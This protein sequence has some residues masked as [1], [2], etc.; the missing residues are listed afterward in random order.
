MPTNNA[1]N[2][3]TAAA[4]KVLQGAGDGVASTFSTA[5]YPSTAGTSGNVLTSNGTNWVSSTLAEL[6]TVTV[7]LTSAQIKALNA[8]S[9]TLIAAQGA[10]KIIVLTSIILKKFYGGTNVFTA[11][12][13]QTINLFYGTTVAANSGTLGTNAVIV[14]TGTVFATAL[15]VVLTAATTTSYENAGIVIRNPVATEISGNAANNN[16]ITVSASYYVATM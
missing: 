9:I 2:Q 3:P 11:A 6:T 1:I 12:A 8:T 5:T 15:P 7:T 13:A 4:G 16:T 10:G 14:S